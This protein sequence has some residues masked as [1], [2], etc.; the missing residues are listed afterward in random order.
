M[1]TNKDFK[2]ALS[3][4]AAERYEGVQYTPANEPLIEELQRTRHELISIHNQATKLAF[5]MDEHIFHIARA[6]IELAREWKNLYDFLSEGDDDF[7]TIMEGSINNMADA[8]SLDAVAEAIH[9]ADENGL[10]VPQFLRDH[11]FGVDAMTTSTRD[12]DF[13][14]DDTDTD[15]GAM[16]G[17]EL[18]TISHSTYLDISDLVKKQVAEQV[19]VQV[20]KFLRENI[21]VN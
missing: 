20:E 10:K 13:P 9:E 17:T 7:A 16:D 15:D 6:I 21:G 19:E 3:K 8:V 1:I 12:V 4:A 14:D 2:E 5:D 11:I 18:K